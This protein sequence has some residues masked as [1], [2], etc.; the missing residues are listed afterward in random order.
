MEYKIEMR[1]VDSLR[2]DPRQPRK[3]F[4]MEAINE[5]ADSIKEHGLIKNIE[6]QPDGTIIT[7]ENRW[8]AAKI[9]G[10]KEI[11]CRVIKI[12]GVDK[13]KRQIAENIHHIPMTPMDIARSLEELA[14]SG[15]D[16]KQISKM[17][18]K[19]PS[20]VSNHLLILRIPPEFQEYFRGQ[21]AI[22]GIR[23]L[24]PVAML[25][26][27]KEIPE[28]STRTIAENLVRYP[29]GKHRAQTLAAHIKENPSKAK[30]FIGVPF[31]L[32]VPDYKLELERIGKTKA[33][34]FMEKRTFEN[35]FLDAL[36]EARSVLD[37][38]PVQTFEDP[39][40]RDS[41]QKSVRYTLEK[42][43]K[44]RSIQHDGKPNR[45]VRTK[46]PL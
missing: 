35:K 3:D 22:D 19:A 24:S 34:K 14:K 43:E 16:Q 41:A 39:V 10:L 40:A 45:L 42:I 15:M 23:V 31:T 11:P 4:S 28:G 33:Q 29:A 25:E 9:A 18:G 2:P 37:R 32:P 8:R 44:W 20:F 36:S 26:K 1:S 38:Y 46:K 21:V 7:G 27:N 12:E 13:A 17:I 6:V 30:E 5:L